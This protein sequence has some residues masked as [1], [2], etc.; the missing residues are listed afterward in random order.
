MKYCISNWKLLV[1]TI[2]CVMAL[3]SIVDAG[4]P[5]GVQP[6]LINQCLEPLPGTTAI[7]LPGNQTVA[8]VSVDK[9]AITISLDNSC[10]YV[11]DVAASDLPEIYKIAAVDIMTGAGAF[12]VVL[13]SSSSGKCSKDPKSLATVCSGLT[14]ESASKI[15]QK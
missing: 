10:S 13:N 5:I 9:N 11:I 7:R 1:I 4:M 8:G 3:G 6:T 14:L 15:I 12:S 2:A